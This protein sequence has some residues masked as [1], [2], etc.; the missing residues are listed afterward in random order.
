MKFIVILLG[1]VF[2]QGLDTNRCQCSELSLQTE[3]MYA[4]CEWETN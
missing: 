4:G 2:A 1:L 3:C